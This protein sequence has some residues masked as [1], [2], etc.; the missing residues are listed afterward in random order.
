[1]ICAPFEQ[2]ESSGVRLISYDRP[3]YGQSTGRPGRTVV[4]CVNDVVTIA[5]A[6]EIGRFVVAG[7]SGG[8]PNALAAAALLPDCV[9]AAATLCGLG[10]MAKTAFDPWFGMLPPREAELRVVYDDPAIFRSNLDKMR[11]N[12]LGLTDE[13]IA[14]QHANAS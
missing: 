7:A 8:G 12:F 13:Q 2:I 6:L 1:M 3:N 14:I 9:T 11:D 5:G 4:D 10:P